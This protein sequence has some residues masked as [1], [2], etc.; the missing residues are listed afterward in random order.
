[1]AL[2]GGVDTTSGAFGGLDEGSEVDAGV[3]QLGTREFLSD[4]GV[5][6]AQFEPF[7]NI[8][9]HVKTAV[10]AGRDPDDELTVLAAFFHSPI[11]LSNPPGHKNSAAVDFIGVEVVGLIVE[12]QFEAVDGVILQGLF[13]QGEPFVANGRVL[14]VETGEPGG[15]RIEIAFGADF[16]V[17]VVEAKV[18]ATDVGL[19]V[20]APLLDQEGG[21]EGETLFFCAL[22]DH[23]KRVVSLPDQIVCILVSPAEDDMR[24]ILH[25]VA[26]EFSHFRV[27]QDRTSV[28]EAEHQRIDGGAE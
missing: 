17:R 8:E 20:G 28:A 26:P 15:F 9:S 4:D 16:Q 11:D 3:V 25:V 12:L 14:E 22:G 1:M 27:V 13:D 19:A 2:E 7:A 24:P 6:N 18:R 10:E 21:V 23:T 5:D